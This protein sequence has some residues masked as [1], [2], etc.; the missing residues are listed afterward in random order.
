MFDVAYMPEESI[1]KVSTCICVTALASNILAAF[2]STAR[3]DDTLVK[4]VSDFKDA[5]EGPDCAVTWPVNGNRET[6]K[7]V[8]GAGYFGAHGP[9]NEGSVMQT[10]VAAWSDFVD[11]V[12]KRK[13]VLSD[14]KVIYSY[15]GKPGKVDRT[16][17]ANYVRSVEAVGEAQLKVITEGFRRAVPVAMKQFTDRGCKYTWPVNGD[18]SLMRIDAPAS[19]LPASASDPKVVGFF[20]SNAYQAFYNARSYARVPFASDC[21]VQLF[22]DGNVN[23]IVVP[24]NPGRSVRERHPGLYAF[25]CWK[26]AHGDDDGRIDAIA[27]AYRDAGF[28]PATDYN[29]HFVPEAEYETAVEAIGGDNQSWIVLLRRAPSKALVCCGLYRKPLKWNDDGEWIPAPPM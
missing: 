17:A 10:A 28:G 4:A 13:A 19:A 21:N 18:P 23:G 11:D 6:L 1:L 27:W 24:A 25:S 14:P 29:R 16:I 8:L 7:L 9:K 20:T 26:V 5:Y 15:A 2:P 12:A 22:I 3:A